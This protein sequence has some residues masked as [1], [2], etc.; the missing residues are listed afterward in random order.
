MS[1]KKN[2]N[3]RYLAKVI[4]IIIIVIINIIALM[5]VVATVGSTVKNLKQDIQT[6]KISK[7]NLKEESR[8]YE[9]KIEDSNIIPEGME[10]ADFEDD[11]DIDLDFKILFKM[12]MDDKD[13]RKSIILMVIALILLAG[14]IYTLIKLK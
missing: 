4:A 12:A 1:N 13:V 3:T 11:M 14:A 7:E 5:S 8:L 6:G 9:N 2:S 10:E